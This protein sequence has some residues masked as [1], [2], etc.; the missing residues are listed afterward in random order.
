MFC[1]NTT[2]PINPTK[3]I[4]AGDGTSKMNESTFSKWIRN[5][6]PSK[7]Y[8]KGLGEEINQTEKSLSEFSSKINPKVYIGIAITTVFALIVILYIL[9]FSGGKIP[10]VLTTGIYKH[11]VW[12]KLYFFEK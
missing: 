5:L 2:K 7:E 4:D 9:L 6:T 11:S 12:D 10:F 3:S 1:A 8:T